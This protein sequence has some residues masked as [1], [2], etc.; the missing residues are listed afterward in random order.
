MKR[1]VYNRENLNSNNVLYKQFGFQKGH[2]TEHAV[3][4]L[5][6]QIS[7]SFEKELFTLGAFIDLSKAFTAVD[8]DTLICKLKNYGVRRSNVKW[9]ESYLNN[10]KQ[11]ISFN[12]RNISF[13]E[14]KCGVPQGSILVP[15]LFLIYGND[16]N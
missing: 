1:I 5:V 11:F 12:K 7:I 4:Q 16:L 14:R 15:L 6:N 13:A 9:F 8:H 10:K 3:L 2:F